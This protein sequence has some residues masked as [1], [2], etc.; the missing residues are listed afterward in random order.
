M[1][2]VFLGHLSPLFMWKASTERGGLRS[3][4]VRHLDNDSSWVPVHT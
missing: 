2:L 3:V 1:L 4:D